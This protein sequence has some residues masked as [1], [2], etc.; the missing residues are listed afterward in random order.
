MFISNLNLFIFFFLWTV[1]VVSQGDSFAAAFR[2]CL[3][4][5]AEACPGLGLPVLLPS[6]GE[7]AVT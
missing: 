1:S 4:S 5:G 3:T 7:I 6:F 2:D